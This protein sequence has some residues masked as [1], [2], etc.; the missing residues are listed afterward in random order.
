MR[1]IAWFLAVIAGTLLLTATVAWPV[2]QLIHALEPDWPFHKILSRFWQV[3]MLAGIALAVWRLRLRRRADW[4]YGLPPGRFLRQAGLGLA[5]GIATM[6]PMALVIVALGIREAR[7]GL[8]A[9][10]LLTGLAGGALTGFAV[11]LIEE[12]FFR[13]LMFRAVLRESG[14]ATALATTAL[15]YSAIHFLTRIRIPHEELGPDSGITLLA[16]ALARFAEPAA[17]A[18]AFVTLVIVGLLLGLVRYWTGGIAAGIGMHMG[19]VCVIKTTA[20]TTRLD[21]TAFWSG[22]VSGFDGFTGWLVA[23][24]GALMLLAVRALRA[25]FA[26]WRK[27]TP[28]AA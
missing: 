15:L 9:A 3:L 2:Y 12:T 18:D 25:R 8:D 5:F 19:W 6:L 11:A 26:D 23:G 20:A 13:G 4:G 28:E 17:I 22:L 7:P 21:E 10:M 1:A 14:L 27:P 24:W 16:A